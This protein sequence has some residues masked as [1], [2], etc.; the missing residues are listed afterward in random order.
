MLATDFARA[1][2][3]AALP[4]ADAAGTAAAGLRLSRSRF[5][6]NVFFLPAR[7]ALPPRLVPPGGAGGGNAMLVLGGVV[8]TVVGTA[9]GGP[10]V[11]RFGWR[12]RST[13][14]RRPTG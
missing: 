1:F 7:S 13:S 4:L 11:D 8:A 14:T 2:V 9:L 10:L 12:R 6:L 5:T 3:V